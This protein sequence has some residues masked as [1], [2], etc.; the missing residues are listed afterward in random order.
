MSQFSRYAQIVMGPAGSGKSTYCSIMQNHAQTLSKTIKVVNLDPAAEIINYNCDLD[1]RDLVTVDDVMDET[2]LGPNGGLV[3][4]MEYLLDHTD[5]LQEA[6]DS[7]SDEDYLIIDCP[8]QIELYTHMTLVRDFIK[9][10]QQLGYN[11]CGVYC[12]DC[13]FI[14]DTYK[15]ISAS[16]MALST[17]NQMEIPSVNVLT[18]CDLIKDKNQLENLLNTEATDMLV[19]VPFY[20]K[21]FK[22][23]TEKIA[24]VLGEFNLVNFIP[25]DVSDEE[26][27]SAVMYQVDI[28]IQYGETLEV[29]ARDDDVDM[30]D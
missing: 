15:F 24:G 28:C 11:I 6:L 17:M 12:I 8:G 19:D 20:S 30:E 10:L 9:S 3:M 5:W 25:L 21:K 2:D 22:N 27:I 1:I 4:A 23:L 29:N 16:L 14:T 13:T 7:F 26:T 18:K